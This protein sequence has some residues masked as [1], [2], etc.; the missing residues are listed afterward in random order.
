MLNHS[1]FAKQCRVQRSGPSIRACIGGGA[2]WLGLRLD[3]WL[4]GTTTLP[5]IPEGPS[6][7]LVAGSTG[8]GTGLGRRFN[9]PARKRSTSRDTQSKKQAQISAHALVA[10]NTNSIPWH[11]GRSLLL[12]ASPFD[13]KC[14]LLQANHAPPN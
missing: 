7:Y 12:K 11:V 3:T 10:A 13:L 6:N 1:C 4:A 2:G 14:G 5:S 9:K 8:S